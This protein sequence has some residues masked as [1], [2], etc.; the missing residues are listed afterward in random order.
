MSIS[1]TNKSSLLL[2]AA[3]LLTTLANAKSRCLSCPSY[4]KCILGTKCV[5]TRSCYGV[6]CLPGEK[7]IDGVCRQ[8]EPELQRCTLFYCT[9][10]GAD[11]PCSHDNNASM[12]CGRWAEEEE[13]L[14]CDKWCPSECFADRPLDNNDTPYCNICKLQIASCESQFEI[15]GPYWL[16]YCRRIYGE[17]C[18]L[19]DNGQCACTSNTRIVDDA[20]V[21][22]SPE[23]RALPY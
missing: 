3:A 22:P 19:A 15:F 16:P 17:G 1:S 6:I 2:I 8:Q 5:P 13:E 21:E 7:C 10:H 11:T 9:K 20:K 23:S 12:T 4:H 18:Y 14:E